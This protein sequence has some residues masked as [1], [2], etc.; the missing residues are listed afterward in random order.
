[1]TENSGLFQKAVNKLVYYYPQFFLTLDCKI[2]GDSVILWDDANLYLSLKMT[3]FSSVLHRPFL[4][5]LQVPCVFIINFFSDAP[6]LK[7]A[8]ALEENKALLAA[9]SN[10]NQSRPVP[11]RRPTTEELEI[12]HR[13]PHPQSVSHPLRSGGSCGGRRRGRQHNEPMTGPQKCCPTLLEMVRN[14]AIYSA[15]KSICHILISSVFVHISY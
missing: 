14:A 5:Y 6:I 10:P 15:V 1:M 13:V 4:L 11:E 8:L 9:H 12:N 2:K 7:S 3:R